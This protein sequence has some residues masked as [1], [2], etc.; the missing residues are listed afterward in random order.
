MQTLLIEIDSQNAFNLIQELEELH[1][2][3]IIR[4]NVLENKTKL[5]EKYK[6]VFSKEDARN[7]IEHSNN[8]RKEWDNT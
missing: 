4:E 1:I 7:F 3:R 6:G 8:M 2:L 5:S